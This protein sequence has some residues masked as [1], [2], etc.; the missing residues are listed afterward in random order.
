MDNAKPFTVTILKADVPNANGRIYPRET[1][2]KIIAQ[3]SENQNRLLGTIGMPAGSTLDLEGVSHAVNNLRI[4]EHGELV[5]EVVIF[6]TPN[7]AALTK[8][9]ED[10][11]VDFRMAGTGTVDESGIVSNYQAISINAVLDG[12]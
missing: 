1:V 4:N 10:C 5:G 7:G 3:C 12:A 2:E 8:M 9:I 11:E 6:D